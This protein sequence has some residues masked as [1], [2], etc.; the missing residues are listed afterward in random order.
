VPSQFKTSIGASYFPEKNT[1]QQ[2]FGKKLKVHL[3]GR[4]K[5]HFF[6]KML[7]FKKLNFGVKQ[8]MQWRKSVASF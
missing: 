6:C 5:S 1:T 4:Q 7:Q 3:H 8:L 2:N